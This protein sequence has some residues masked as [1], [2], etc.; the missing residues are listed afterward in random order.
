MP[1]TSFSPELL[2]KILN[3]LTETKKQLAEIMSG[4]QAPTAAK[5]AKA[6][7]KGKVTSAD[8][9]ALAVKMFTKAGFQ[10]VQPRVNY[11]LLEKPIRRAAG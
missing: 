11:L 6:N 3:E 7:G 2:S 4:Q 8:N 10:N 1:E 5:P 9:D